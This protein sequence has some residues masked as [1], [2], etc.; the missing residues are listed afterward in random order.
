M[1]FNHDRT[2]KQLSFLHQH[3]MF[4]NML[5]QKHALHQ[6]A[7]HFLQASAKIPLKVKCWSHH[8]RICRWYILRFKI[9]EVHKDHDFNFQADF[10]YLH[11][12]NGMECQSS[13]ST[14]NWSTNL[15]IMQ[16]IKIKLR[17][18]LLNIQMLTKVFRGTLI[19]RILTAQ[20]NLQFDTWKHIKI[21]LT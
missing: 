16:K 7:W 21:K 10:L 5:D 4:S 3:P 2:D 18:K 11:L 14:T 15:Q 1:Q 20:V 8:N 17:K 6:P 19:Y 9:I 13:L 12:C